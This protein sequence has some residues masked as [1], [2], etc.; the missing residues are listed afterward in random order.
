MPRV[1]IVIDSA[2]DLSPEDAARNGI[3]L[4]P[5]LVTFG[6]TEYRT[7][8]D[9]S[10]ERFW[11]MMTAPGAPFPKTAACSPGDF[12]AAFQTAFDAGAESVVC[13]TVGGKLS[14]TNK[15]A[16][17]ARDQM[18]GRDIRVIDSDTASYGFGLLAILA[19][20]MSGAGAGADE[21]EAAVEA[22]K[23]DSR[24][25][26]VLETLEYL[27]RG[28]RISAAKAAIGGILS[29]KPI[30]TIEDGVVE[31]ADQPRTRSKARE[32]LLEL[33]TAKPIER[34]VVLS[35]MATDP[36]AFATELASEAGL[37]A[38]LIPVRSIGPSVGPHVGPGAYG[39][40]VLYRS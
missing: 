35:A 25:F 24:L 23:H 22:R 17:I 31:T 8:V 9:L 4:V 37:A 7:G 34:A 30:I 6:T 28:G 3:A 18:A 27:K 12:Q 20:E 14:A 33:I 2:S 13:I 5:L 19:S 36:G 10:T 16:V 26:V 40:V 15:S 1:A 38:G 39:A 21:I 32:R 11:D 29:V